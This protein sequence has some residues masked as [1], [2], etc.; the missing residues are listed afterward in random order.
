MCVCVCKR[1]C[2][3]ERVCVSSSYRFCSSWPTGRP[4][5]CVCVC[6]SLLGGAASAVCL[7]REV[8]TRLTGMFWKKGI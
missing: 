2:V 5:V 3:C 8:G 7:G 1:A 6:V 4:C